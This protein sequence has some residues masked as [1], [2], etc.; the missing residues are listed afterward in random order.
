MLRDMQ[1]STKKEGVGAV[2]RRIYREQGI[3]GFYKGWWVY[4][5]YGFRSGI[6]VTSTASSPAVVLFR[7]VKCAELVRFGAQQ[8]MFDQMKVMR[9]SSLAARGVIIQ[10]TLHPLTR[11][12]LC[13]L[14]IK[15]HRPA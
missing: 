8:S 13:L 7:G 15:S 10:Y 9:I 1:T 12:P 4:L 11:H 6:Q 3:L 2:T 14:A 5:L